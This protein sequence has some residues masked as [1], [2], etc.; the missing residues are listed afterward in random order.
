[1]ISD[2]DARFMAG[3]WCIDTAAGTEAPGRIEATD[4]FYRMHNANV[5]RG[6]HTLS[7]E[8]TDAYEAGRQSLAEFIN[9]GSAREVISPAARP[10]RSTWWRRVLCVPGWAPEM[11]LS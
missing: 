11:K 9:A 7:Q 2:F 10:S 5:H 3:R 4:S 1:V 8:A 6:V